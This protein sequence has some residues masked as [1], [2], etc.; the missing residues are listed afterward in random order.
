MPSLQP[1]ETNIYTIA[2]GLTTLKIPVCITKSGLRKRWQPSIASR[3]TCVIIIVP[4]VKNHGRKFICSRCKRDKKPC[5]LYFAN[6]DMDPGSRRAELQGLSEVK[7]LLI[8][9]TFP[10]MSI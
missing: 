6:N 9:R 2:D 1:G 10:I 4:F 8:A 7:E 3:K 5:R